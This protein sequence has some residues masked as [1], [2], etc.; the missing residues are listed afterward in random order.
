MG[1]DRIRINPE[2][3]LKEIVK[4]DYPN[5]PPYL[6]K[7]ITGLYV[8]PPEKVVLHTGRMMGKST[9]AKAMEIFATESLISHFVFETDTSTYYI[10]IY[11]NNR[12]K[13]Y[14][15]GFKCI[16]SDPMEIINFVKKFAPNDE[17]YYK[18]EGGILG[19][20]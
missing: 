11:R 13:M 10:M 1:T 2:V 3:Y 6:Q 16:S 17:I 18:I 7:L 8:D 9:M 19:A 4:K 14:S 15:N 12:I 5:A 20:M